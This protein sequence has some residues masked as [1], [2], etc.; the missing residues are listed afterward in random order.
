MLGFLGVTVT[1]LAIIGMWAMHRTLR[2]IVPT[3]LFFAALLLAGHIGNKVHGGS[4]LFLFLP[5][6]VAIVMDLVSGARAASLVAVATEWRAGNVPARCDALATAGIDA[7][8]RDL[9]FLSLFQLFAP[10]APASILVRPEDHE[11]ALAV[12]ATDEARRSPE[13]EPDRRTRALAATAALAALGAVLVA[14]PGPA[15]TMPP[16]RRAHLEIR[17]VDDE[18]TLPEEGLSPEL[19]LRTETTPVGVKDGMKRTERHDYVYV[20]MQPGETLDAAIARGERLTRSLTLPAGSS[21]LWEQ[22]ADFDAETGGR[23]DIGAR[24]FV[25]T[26]PPIV[27]TEDI[28]EAIASISDPDGLAE[29]FVAV[30]LSSVAATRFEQATAVNVNRRLAIVLDGRVSSAPVIRTAISGGRLSISMGT[31]AKERQMSDAKLL[32]RQLKGP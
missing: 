24:A 1:V 15:T 29:P 3:L 22:I 8:T 27:T 13:P 28:D 30:V 17:R 19:E 25:V 12:L 7:R 26:G 32:A 4:F 14:A 23:K 31:N 9:A 2:G 16:I 18:A 11:R 10:Y 20:T 5:I 6:F 21:L